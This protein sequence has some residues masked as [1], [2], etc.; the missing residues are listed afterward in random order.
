M[1][2]VSINAN[3]GYTLFLAGQFQAAEIEIRKT[4]EMD[5]Y[6]GVGHMSLAG[7]LAYQ[8]K[9]GEAVEAYKEALLHTGGMLRWA[10]G[11][12]A[13]SSRLAGNHAVAREFQRWLEGCHGYVPAS[14]NF[15]AAVGVG[16]NE[17][18][19]HFLE[20]AC[21]EHDTLLPW[22]MVDQTCDRLRRTP[23]FKDIFDRIARPSPRHAD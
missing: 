5:P 22:I 8:G 16:E 17:K 4:L 15:L 21:R 10:A 19:Y 14:A 6:Y 1:P 3:V 23:R 18:A 9:Y 20:K 2:A 11:F 12:A 7:L 13:Y